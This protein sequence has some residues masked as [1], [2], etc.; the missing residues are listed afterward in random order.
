MAKKSERAYTSAKQDIL[1]ASLRHLELAA[2]IY[3]LLARESPWVTI[4]CF[5]A[6]QGAM[7]A[8]KE[9]AQ[10]VLASVN[11][12]ISTQ[13]FQNAGPGSR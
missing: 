12:V 11:P 10:D 7:R 13:V 1:E 4:E 3:D 9:I 2:G 5:D 8:P 6:A